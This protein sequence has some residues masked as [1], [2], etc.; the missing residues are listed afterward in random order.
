MMRVAKTALGVAVVGSLL[1]SGASAFAAT[2]PVGGTIKVWAPFTQD[3]PGV[4]IVIT[5]AIA[6]SG[7][8]VAANSA[9][10]PT[11][12][13]EYVKLVLKKGTVL[14]DRTQLGAANAAAE[15]PDFNDVNCSGSAV[16]SAPVPI[17]SGTK[18][19]AG[20]T[21]SVAMT[22]TYAFIL[23]L[24]SSGKCDE[25]NVDPPVAFWGSLAGSGTVSFG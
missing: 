13:G 4:P 8:G 20:I 1:F 19:Y 5:G 11:K 24:T 15:S 18:S 9:G 7:K 21:G 10:K 14:I 2:A 16:A 3:E 23:P 17:V 25:S 6:D 22:L 12:N